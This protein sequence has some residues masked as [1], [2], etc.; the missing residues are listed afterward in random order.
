MV[1]LVEQE[2]PTLPEHL[3]SARVGF[4]LL[5]LY[6]PV[7]YCRS[8]FVFFFLFLLSIALSVLLRFKDSDY[9][10][11]ISELF[12]HSGKKETKSKDAKI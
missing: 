4:E 7:L 8:L 9:P 2:L 6:F 3:S 10:F 5:N 11:G 12:L 1:S